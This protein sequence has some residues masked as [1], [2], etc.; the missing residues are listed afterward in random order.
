MAIDF[1]I[2]SIQPQALI[3]GVAGI[4]GAAKA[5]ASSATGFEQIFSET[6]HKVESLRGDSDKQL[7]GFLKGENDDPHKMI[8]SMQEADLSFQLFLQ[9]RN[10]FTNAYTE[11]MRMQL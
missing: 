11:V 1:N 7:E 10:K 9:V 5:K 4:G 2:Q 6:M 8:L 3:G